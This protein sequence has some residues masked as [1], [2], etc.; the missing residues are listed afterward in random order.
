MKITGQFQ[1]TYQYI[2]GLQE[3]KRVYSFSITHLKDA[4][5]F[6]A[7]FGG[8]VARTLDYEY[9]VVL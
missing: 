2:A 5:K 7:L 3:A 6:A 9:I 4:K 1:R 8:S